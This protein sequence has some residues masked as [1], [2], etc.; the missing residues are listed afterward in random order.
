MRRNSAYLAK[1]ETEVSAIAKK[2]KDW[3]VMG[4]TKVRI[5]D[6]V[7][8]LKLA[9]FLRMASQQMAAA[10]AHQE[11]RGAQAAGGFSRPHQL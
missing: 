11:S 1:G 4:R 2:L 10:E 3:V 7:G 9:I 8:I 6:R 5:T